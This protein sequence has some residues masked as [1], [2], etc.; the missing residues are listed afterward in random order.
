MECRSREL[1]CLLIERQL[2]CLG[3]VTRSGCKAHCPARGVPCE[4]CRG[5]APDANLGEFWRLLYEA[6]RSPAEVR[7]RL[8]RFV[9]GG[10][11]P[12]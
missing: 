2:A 7:G 3:P 5:P 8:E 9:R 11:G 6:G 1:P 10:D 4:G 12:A